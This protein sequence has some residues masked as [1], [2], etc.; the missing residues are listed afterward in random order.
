V[1]LKYLCLS[2]GIFCFLVRESYVR[3]VGRYCFVR[4]NAAIP[5]QFEVV[6]LQHVCWLVL[7]VWAFVFN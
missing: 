4:H 3:S 2:K 1:Y 6:V 7:I 5:V